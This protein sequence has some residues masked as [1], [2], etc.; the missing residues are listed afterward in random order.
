GNTQEIGFA[1]NSPFGR[2]RTNAYKISWRSELFRNIYG[3]KIEIQPRLLSQ[4]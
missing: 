1:R 2:L 4:A 3:R